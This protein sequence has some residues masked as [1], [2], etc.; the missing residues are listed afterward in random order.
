MPDVVI[1][2]EIEL[3]PFFAADLRQMQ[4]ARNYQR[5]Q[6]RLITP[7]LGRTVLEV[8]GGIGTFTCEL[9]RR[10]ESVVSLEPNAFCYAQ[11]NERTR[12]LPNVRALD[13]PVEALSSAMS[14][15]WRVDSVVCMNVLEHIQDDVAALR[16]FA[17]RLEPQGRVIIT[18]PAGGW[19][20]GEIDRR[21]G[22]YRRY[23]KRTLRAAFGRAGLRVQHLRY[24]NS[25]GIWAWWWNAKFG[26]RQAQSDFQIKV[27][28]R[29]I[30]PWLSR[31]ESLVPP[32]VGQS[33]LAVGELG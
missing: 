32:L 2:P 5:W 12:A 28:D 23:D 9:A 27:F 15:D 10:V 26:G 31:L 17:E 6:M 3:D 7:H 20:Y 30:V 25:I 33:L 16:S 24:F 19:A 22:H 21:L 29:G 18:V 13:M 1:Q 14:G 11:L 8:G 4:Q